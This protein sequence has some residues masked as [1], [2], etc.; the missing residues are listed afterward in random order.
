MALFNYSQELTQQT[1]KDPNR[2][3]KLGKFGNVLA[4]LGGFKTT[5]TGSGEY[6]MTG[7][8]SGYGK[9]M[10]YAMPGFAGSTHLAGQVATKGTQTGEVLKEG[11]GEALG[12]T[13]AG[14][15][16]AK[17]V[18]GFATGG[19]GLPIGGK[20]AADTVSASGDVGDAILDSENKNGLFKN[21][22]SGDG[23][24]FGGKSPGLGEMQSGSPEHQWLQWSNANWDPTVETLEEAKQR[25]YQE[26]GGDRPTPDGTTDTPATDD[27]TTTDTADN[28]TDSDKEAL[29]LL[30]A[31]PVVGELGKYIAAT[32]IYNKS[33]PQDMKDVRADM[34]VNYNRNLLKKGGKV[35]V[36]GGMTPGKFSH[37]ENPLI[38]VD[39]NGNDT[40]ME[41]T[42]GEGVFDDKAMKTIEKLSRGGKFEKLGR[43]VDKEMKTWD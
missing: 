16:L 38:V 39:K 11:A 35:Y 24:L 12:Q 1:I 32:D 30:D 5:K 33:A 23:K 9:V 37:K 22:F 27:D 26:T 28:T 10:N 31:A 42:G 43:Y 4:N 13:V 36:D 2:Y 40:G 21:L 14:L 8:R 29:N 7:E 17:E 6:M 34:N 18:V 19:A 41:L 25:Y 3:K 15:N 20:N